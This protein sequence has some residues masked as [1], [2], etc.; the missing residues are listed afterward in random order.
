MEHH[1]IREL[2]IGIKGAGEMASAV[3]WRLYMANLRKVFM[4]EIP[5]PLAVRRGVCFC[6]A[7]YDRCKTVEGVDANENGIRDDVELAI[8]EKIVSF[9]KK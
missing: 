5:R 4:M 8:F 3:A 1:S 7:I 2:S 9:T 6:E